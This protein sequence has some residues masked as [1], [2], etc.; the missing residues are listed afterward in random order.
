MDN[1]VTLPTALLQHPRPEQWLRFATDG[2]LCVYSGKVELGQGLRT[3]LAQIVAE[4]LGLDP[5]QLTMV[6]A[7][8][9]ISPDEGVT[10]GSQSVQE[11]GRALR[12]VSA[13]LRQRCLAA[14]A[15]R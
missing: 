10:S 8:T 7:A 15:Q 1:P 6:A 11:S 5:A 9:D 4:E 13:E 3:A 2:S 14:A 12:L